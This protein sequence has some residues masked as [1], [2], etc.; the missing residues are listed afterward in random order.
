MKHILENSKRNR[1]YESMEG[2]Y[3]NSWTGHKKTNP[4]WAPPIIECLTLEMP[5]DVNQQPCIGK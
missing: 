1:E 3:R 4:Q 2:N 5:T